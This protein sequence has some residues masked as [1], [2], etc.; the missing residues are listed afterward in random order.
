MGQEGWNGEKK[1]HEERERHPLGI[2]QLEFLRFGNATAAAG[3]PSSSTTPHVW[4]HHRHISASLLLSSFY[5]GV[6][7]CS[8]PPSSFLSR[9]LRRK[10]ITRT[11]CGHLPRSTRP[12]PSVTIISIFLLR[13][14]RLLF[15]HVVPLLIH[16]RRG[17][18]RKRR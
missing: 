9:V 2:F 12:S 16:R 1:V 14:I 10:W 4:V 13:K 11:S 18:R 5:C 6:Y 17:R 7:R 3:V 15:P 8:D